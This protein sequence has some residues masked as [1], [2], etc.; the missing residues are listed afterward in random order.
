MLLIIKTKRKKMTLKKLFLFISL[1]FSMAYA[2][3]PTEFSITEKTGSYII[4]SS[5]VKPKTWIGLYKKGTTNEWEN[6]KAWGWVKETPLTTIRIDI[7]E[8][9][10]Y[11]ARLFFNNSFITAKSIDFN[12]NAGPYQRF[13]RLKDITISVDNSQQFNLTYSGNN[14]PAKDWV[15]IFPKDTAHTRDNLVAWGFVTPFVLPQRTG[16]V[17]IKTISEQN[18]PLGQYDMVYFSNDTYLELGGVSTLTVTNEFTLSY[19]QHRG[20]YDG[21][22]ILSLHKYQNVAQPN[23]WVGIFN[24]EDEPTRDNLIAWA[25]VR[26]GEVLRDDDYWKF[27]Y[28]S[29]F[30]KENIVNTH[31]VIL[32]SNDSYNILGE[33]I[34]HF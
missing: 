13:D 30:P 4:F 33:T 12:I 18:L 14:P 1:L 11:Q 27:F 7:L 26:D 21:K 6:V 23:D 2:E 16:T 24:I 25:Y 29:N 22:F 34:V 15:G 32:F 8:S 10:D 19:D 5:T 9:G 3:I 17:Q 31:K 28:F 20:I